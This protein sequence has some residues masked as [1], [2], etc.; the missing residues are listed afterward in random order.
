MRISPGLREVWWPAASKRSQVIAHSSRPLIPG[1]TAAIA[2][3][4]ASWTSA[5]HSAIVGC[6][7]PTQN[8]RAMS[9]WHA[10]SRSCGARSTIT[11]SPGTIRP[12]P[13]PWPS[14]VCGPCRTM[15]SASKP[16]ASRTMSCSRSQ[17]RPV[18]VRSAS[19]AARSPSSAACVARRMPAIS[20]AVFTRRRAEKS[21][22][23][24]VSSIPPA[25][26]YSAVA[27]GNVG[28]TIAPVRPDLAARAQAHLEHRLVAVHALV[29]QPQQ[30]EL[31]H[32]D[33]LDLGPR[34]RD[35]LG[36]ERRDR[37]ERA[38]VTLA[39]EERIDDRRGN[40]VAQFGR[41]DCVGID[42]N[43]LGH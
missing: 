3:S 33:L 14:A 25:R 37:R 16:T 9:V 13:G 22:W 5:C 30:P 29:D 36:I 27:S 40:L 8:V 7:S 10:D 39:V 31:G 32:V 12:L 18:V 28:G 1:R 4:S 24:V 23:S 42:Q 21:S 41:P 19:A 6:G 35:Q 15:M 34:L 38:S 17:V 20:A 26:R 43:V 11:G 2:A